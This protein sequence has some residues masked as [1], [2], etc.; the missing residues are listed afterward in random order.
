M[1][2][3]RFGVQVATGLLSPE[4]TARVCWPGLPGSRAGWGCPGPAPLMPP[5]DTAVAPAPRGARSRP[6][7]FPLGEKPEIAS[8]LKDRRPPLKPLLPPR[9][10]GTAR[11]SPA[12]PG[13]RAPHTPGSGPRAPHLPRRRAG[14]RRV[15]PRCRAPSHR[16]H[17]RRGARPVNTDTRER[18]R[19]GLAPAPSPP[20]PRPRPEA[21]RRRAGG[22]PA[23]SFSPWPPVPPRSLRRA[24]PGLACRRPASPRAQARVRAP[25]PAA[26]LTPR[27]PGFGRP[28]PPGSLLCCSRRPAAAHGRNGS[29]RAQFRPPPPA[30]RTG[31]RPGPSPR[32]GAGHPH[33]PAASPQP[34]RAPAG[35]RRRRA[36]LPEVR[37]AGPSAPGFPLRRRPPVTAGEEL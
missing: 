7:A 14:R 33:R 24:G 23:P 10:S 31:S 35:P 27:L 17:P 12:P 2:G 22:A 4:G 29:A 26:L 5:A 21:C 11:L 30:R 19:R 18:P 15:T 9:L 36:A 3:T 8:R 25:P 37:P 16:P 6:A 20:G 13:R 34:G 28:R 32:P 1:T